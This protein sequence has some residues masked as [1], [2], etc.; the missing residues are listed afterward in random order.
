MTWDAKSF[1]FH[2]GL[3]QVSPSRLGIEA[4]SGMMVVNCAY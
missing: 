3:F 4:L 2:C 1:D